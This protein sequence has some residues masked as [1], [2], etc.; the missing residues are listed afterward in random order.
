[1]C[2]SGCL[3]MHNADVLELYDFVVPGTKVTIED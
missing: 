2:S 1:M 3:R